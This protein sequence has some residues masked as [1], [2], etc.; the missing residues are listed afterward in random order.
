MYTWEIEHWPN[1]HEAFSRTL[2]SYFDSA[3]IRLAI[4]R[5]SSGIQGQL[6]TGKTAL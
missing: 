2:G 3:S 1:L 6:N 5:A 4:D